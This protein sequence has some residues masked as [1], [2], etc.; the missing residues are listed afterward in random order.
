MTTSNNAA[1][2]L[3]ELNK[4]QNFGGIGATKAR[5]VPR[6]DMSGFEVRKAEIADQLW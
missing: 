3:A 2:G 5:D 4:E 1:Y 6:I